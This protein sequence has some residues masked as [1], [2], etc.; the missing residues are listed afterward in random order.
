M[1][2][3]FPAPFSPQ[4]QWHTPLLMSMQMSSRARTPGY[5]LDRFLIS[6]M[7]SLI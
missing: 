3:D 2:V 4:M 1:S 5:C 7:F 6:R